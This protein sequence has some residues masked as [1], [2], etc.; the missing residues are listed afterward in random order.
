MRGLYLARARA[1]TWLVACGSPMRHVR[2]FR[3]RRG[4]A[5]ASAEELQAR[6]GEL[7][8]ERQQL[9]NG[10]AG[11]SALERNRVRIAR[12][13]WELGHALIERNLPEPA[14]TAAA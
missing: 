9:R 10:G 3:F 13:Q 11:A 8:A 12:A 14:E 4:R 5:R 2:P 1:D 7:V 6:I